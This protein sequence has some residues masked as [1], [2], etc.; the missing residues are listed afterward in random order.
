[1]NTKKTEE[2]FVILPNSEAELARRLL[3]EVGP[4]RKY[5][6]EFRMDRFVPGAEGY[7]D[8]VSLVRG[9]I[10]EAVCE[11]RCLELLEISEETIGVRFPDVVGFGGDGKVLYKEALEKCPDR[12]VI[13]K[14]LVEPLY[15]SYKWQRVIYWKLGN[16]EELLQKMSE[17]FLLVEKV[18][19]CL[20]SDEIEDLRQGKIV[21]PYHWGGVWGWL[22]EYL[23]TFM[24]KDGVL[25]RVKASLSD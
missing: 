2:T 12:E 20:F 18:G 24:V 14:L 16:F 10:R 9:G 3:L 25:F 8:M 11:E 1:M 21:T 13:E 19:V 4:F 17:K 23:D 7:P 22:V 6:F 5:E 15:R